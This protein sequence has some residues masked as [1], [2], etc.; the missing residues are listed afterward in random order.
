MSSDEKAISKEI[1]RVRPILA[2]ISMS[3]FTLRMR[4]GDDWA[5][6]KAE[7]LLDDVIETLGARLEMRGGK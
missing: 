4:V 1:N 5:L 7:S 3:L 6:V 2:E